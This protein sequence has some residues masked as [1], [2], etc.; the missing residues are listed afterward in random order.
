MKRIA[1]LLLAVFCSAFVEQQPVEW[2]QC[3]RC[4]CCHCKVPGDCGMPCSR[5]P[6]PAAAMPAAPEH[7]LAAL[8]AA[9][10][11]QPAPPAA[12]KFYASF[13]ELTT[14]PVALV[15]SASAGPA[16]S[17]PLYKAHCSFLI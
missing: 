14:L 3:S 11:R 15:A 16:A 1:W 2:A 17:G 10:I 13:V 9:R 4:A 8:P 5:A 12:A 6:A 7:A